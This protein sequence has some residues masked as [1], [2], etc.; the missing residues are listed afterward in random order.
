M[1]MRLIV[2]HVIRTVIL[3]NNIIYNV[4]NNNDHNF[5]VDIR[6]NDS[7]IDHYDYATLFVHEYCGL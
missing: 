1:L 6:D 5:D 4:I 3:Y 7:V 2:M